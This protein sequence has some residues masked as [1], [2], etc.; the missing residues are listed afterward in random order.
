[1]R[2]T[3]MATLV[4]LFTLTGI[5]QAAIVPV[6]S[7][8]PPFAVTNSSVIKT[9][10]GV[11]FGVYADAGRT[12]GSLR[13][14]GA[15]GTTFG[16]LTALGYTYNYNTS[17]NNPLGAPYLRVFLDANGDGTADNDVIFDPTLCATV[18]PPENTD[19]VVDVTTQTVRFN[20]DSC[21]GPA[22]QQP[23]AAVKAAHA[24]ETIVGIFVTQGDAGGLD[25]SAYLRNLT[26]NAD[27]YAFNV[28]PANGQPGAPAA[29]SPTAG[30][31]C[32]GDTIRTLHAPRRARAQFLRVNAALLTGAGFRKLKAVRRTVKLD[33]RNKA[34]GNYNVRLI[35]HYRT[36]SGKVLR[37][38][39]WRHFSVACA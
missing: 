28:P 18:T 32:T 30:A 13:Y 8:T 17:N 10:D 25:A 1:M 20:D 37:D 33:L 31:T 4:A 36:R 19:N 39:T 24:N 23:F 35:S 29:P 3:I 27:T 15:N 26:V 34:E 2:K 9:P 5:A 6:Q 21:A 11:H 22:T 14:D 12:G 16:S 7:L 38:V